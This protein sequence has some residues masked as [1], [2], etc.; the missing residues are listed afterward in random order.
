MMRLISSSLNSVLFTRVRSLVIRMPV[1]ALRNHME[2][3]KK[4]FDL[5]N[6]GTVGEFKLVLGLEQSPKT[7]EVD[8]QRRASDPPSS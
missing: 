4:I 8:S 5:H 2:D 1:A 7:A 3:L 6:F